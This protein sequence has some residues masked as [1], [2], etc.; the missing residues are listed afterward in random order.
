[1]AGDL[2]AVRDYRSHLQTLLKRK[3]ATVNNA[4]AAVDDLYIRRGLGPANA[5]RA[6]LPRT[7]PKGAQHA[8]RGAVPARGPALPLAS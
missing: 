5:A 6:E 8:H 7:A 4:L 1:M 3:P 2:S